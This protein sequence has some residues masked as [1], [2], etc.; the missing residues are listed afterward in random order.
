MNSPWHNIAF[1]FAGAK[2]LVTGGTSGIGK[3]IADA[4]L[5]AGADVSITGT[6]AS[7]SA[8]DEDLSGFD[9]LRLDIE[10]TA[11]VDAAVAALPQLDVLIN[12]AGFALYTTGLDEHDPDVFDRSMRM[13][14]GGVQRLS[15]RCRPALA[16]SRLPGGAA[17]VNIASMSSFFGY[18]I[19]P[20]YGTAKTA[21][22]GLTRQ[23]AVGFA[24]D[25]IRVNALAVG[26]T[27]SRMTAGFFATPELAGPMLARTPLGRTAEPVD[28]AGAALF[29]CSDAAAWITGQTLPVDGGFSIKG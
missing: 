21:V 29:L 28:I 14:V 17:I 19:T 11:S 6:R 26:L 18:D 4:F 1:T 2:V 27:R 24:A 23:H 20:A 25:R 7:P 5:A 16:R 12:N 22:L 9:F 15:T 13:L 10:D 3:G 8:Y